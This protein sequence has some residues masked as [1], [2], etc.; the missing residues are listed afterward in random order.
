[1]P[2]ASSPHS[3]LRYTFFRFSTRPAPPIKFNHNHITI[4]NTLCEFLMVVA[5][6]AKV[7]CKPG[8]WLVARAKKSGNHSE[9]F[10]APQ[11]LPD[12]S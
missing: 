10:P 4:R 3:N 9:A 1:M 8:L 6:V 5:A 12:F 2:P 11:Q 7:S